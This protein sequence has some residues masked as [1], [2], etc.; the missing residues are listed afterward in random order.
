MF[1][2][3][4][5][6]LLWLFGIFMALAP[7][8]N[9]ATSSD[10]DDAF[11]Q[12]KDIKNLD[13]VVPTVVEV[14]IEYFYLERTEFAVVDQTSDIL[15]PYY[16]K[17][18]IVTT[19]AS[20]SVTTLPAS[21]RAYRMTDKT[22]KTYTEFE[23]DS[24][25]QGT[26]IINLKSSIP[27]TSSAL[28]TL[29]ATNVALPTSVEISATVDG[30]IKKILAKSDM[31][32]QTIRF[33]E[34][35]AQNWKIV[36]TYAQPLRIN[37]IRLIQENLNKNNDQYVR[38]LAQPNR[39]YRVYFDPDRYVAINTGESGNLRSDEDVLTIS[40][41]PSI[42]NPLYVQAD[43]DNDGIPDILDNCVSVPNRDQKDINEN[44]RGD[45]CEDFDKDG[46]MNDKDNCPNDP[47]RTQRDTDRDK[48]GDACD[49]EESRLT[50]KYKWIPWLG[51]VFA[52]IVI[53]VLFI[54]TARSKEHT[55]EIEEEEIQDDQEDKQIE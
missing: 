35:T 36:F 3:N 15:L 30:K 18:N 34:T 53:V 23:L 49:I 16:Y 51:I 17:K 44:G 50:E 2:V 5:K 19:E 45:T 48:I 20:Y 8:V 11:R 29:L 10:V 52:L 41:V 39:S 21:S 37:E 54:V 38:F 26:V 32:Q 22:S 4:K 12:Y 46:V 42:A 14:P 47:N 27:V 33:P 40:T 28:V 9:A 6:I 13:I 24:N 43:V 7:V 1:K 25:D 55:E 31:R